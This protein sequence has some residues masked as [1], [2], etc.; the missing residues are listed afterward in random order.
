[1]SENEE[2]S[3]VE[4]S[5]VTYGSASFQLFY[6]LMEETDKETFDHMVEVLRCTLKS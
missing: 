2:M 1:M 6:L 3:V 5:K 4:M